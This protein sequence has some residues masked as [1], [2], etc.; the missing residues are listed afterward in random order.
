MKQ[1]LAVLLFAVLSGHLARAQTSV[2]PVNITGSQ[3][4]QINTNNSATV[5]IQVTGTWTGTI[6]P[7]GSIQGKAA[8]NVSVTPQGSTTPQSTITANGAYSVSTAGLDTFQACGNTVT[9][10]ATI[11]M[12]SS[13]YVNAALISGGGGGGG[14]AVSSVSGDGNFVNNVSSTGNVALTLT[15]AAGN[16]VWGRSLGTTGPASYFAPSLTS[17]LFANQGTT[18]TVLHGNAA[19]NPTFGA[20]SLA[21]DVTGNLSVNNL[22]SG[23]AASSSTF[24]RGDGTW[25]TPAGGGGTPCTTT[26][27]SLQFNSAGSFGCVPDFTF[28]TPHTILSGASGILDLHAAAVG[29]LF[30]PGALST[31]IVTV[32][33]TTGAISSFTPGSG[34]QTF[35]TT[36]SSAN[37]FAAITDETG[38]GLVV[39]NNT[40]ALTT[41]KVTTI[42]DANGNPFIASSATASAVDSITVTNSA[43]GNPATVTIAGSGSDSN[44]NLS[45]SGKGTGVAQ[46]ANGATATTQTVGDNTTKVATDAFVLANAVTNPMTTL[47]DEIYGGASGVFT[48]LAG[49]TATN[50]VPQVLTSTP[51][52]GAAT[53]PAWQPNGVPAD[54]QTGTTYTILATDRETYVTFSNAASIAVT[55]PQAGTTGFASNFAFVACDIGA[56]TATITPTTGTISSSN[57]T[58]YT[59]GASTLALTTGQCA[60]IYSDNTN[61]FAI[62]RTGGSGSGTV[63]SIATTSPITGG[64][65][66]STGTIACATCGVTGTGLQQFASTTSAQL[67]GVLSD[68]TGT[69]LA[70]FNT[71]PLLVT[72]KVTTINDAN[73]NPFILS[74]ATASA[75][76]GITVTNAATANPATVAVAS[77][78]SDTN[79]HLQLNAKGTGNVMVG[80]ATNCTPGTAGGLCANEGTAPTGVAS[81]GELWP[82]SGTHV[83]NW[84][85]NNA[86]AQHLPVA[87]VTAGT[88][89]TNATTTFS[90]VVG[91]SGPTLAIPVN[92]STSYAITCTIIWQASANTAGPKF[93]WTGPASPTTLASSMTSAVTTTT[94]I[95]A[96]ATAFSSAMANSGTVTTATNQVATVTL[97]LNNGVNAGTVT[98]QAAANGS[99]TLTIEPGS[100]CIGQ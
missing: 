49:P 68:E 54:A 29:G 21:N 95:Q 4:A 65:I 27:L 62:V 57:G 45:L 15:N 10:T 97:G 93:Q 88:A 92:A 46:L 2:G 99:G 64:T 9:N 96:T 40:P 36:P 39:G 86:T 26:A 87:L 34:V 79:I 51:S 43:T 89:Y 22:N 81:V 30:L 16:T 61:Y 13:P 7:Q 91:G 47:G 77:T 94:L 80:S 19:G 78:G 37:F 98:L 69:S 75:V 24:W 73:G 50:G 42:N 3:C 84:N 25:A 17:A 23:T 76:D 63:T 5:V 83:W 66:T 70:V 8:F 41:P 38:S 55:L 53:A 67:A 1:A 85:S 82:D 58:A 6:Q 20:V 59:A 18:T 56:G 12:N 35:L 14:G 74:S 60:W 48:R 90:S 71:S 100:D 11:N 31:G 28:S 33:T 32:A 52:A 72:P 44:V